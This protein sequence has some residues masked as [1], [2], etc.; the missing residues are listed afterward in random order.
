[1]LFLYLLYSVNPGQTQLVANN[2]S[3]DQ[4]DAVNYIKDNLRVHKLQVQEPVLNMTH[5][6]S[7]SDRYDIAVPSPSLI[8]TE[9][10]VSFFKTAAGETVFSQLALIPEPG[11]VPN[12]VSITAAERLFKALFTY[13]D[14]I[15]ALDPSIHLENDPKYKDSWKFF[16]RLES[17]LYPWIY[18]HWDNAF[19]INNQT[20]GRG[21]V[22][23]V[24]NNQ[25][26]FAATT[27]RAIRQLFH[28]TLPIEVFFI[29]DSDL[30]EAKRQ[31]LKSEFQDLQLIKLEDYVS[32]YYT[33]FGGWAMKP[34]AILA[35]RFT[36]VVMMDADVFFF[37][38]PGMLFEDEGYK[39]TGSLF[40]YD[41]TLLPNSTRG[42]DW[43]R[44]FLPSMSSFVPHSRWFKQVSTHEQESGVIVMNKRKALLGLLSTCKLNSKTERD[45]LVYK[46]V[47]GDKETFWIGFEVMQTPYAFV[48]SF[49]GV[50]GDHGRGGD[51]GSPDYLCGNEIH[52]DANEKPLWLN[53][54]LY[55]NK[56]AK[57]GLEY[58]NF[59]YYAFGDEWELKSGCLKSKENMYLLDPEQKTYALASI[60]LDKK[61]IEDQRL[62]EKGEW[63]FKD[64]L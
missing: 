18:P 37:Q 56:H 5:T 3:V 52:F 34:F 62:L 29:R 54:G 12:L 13:F 36:E 42:P 9:Q 10:D 19:H 57:N 2:S 4:F 64:V 39:A 25:F 48:K 44:S 35:S 51:D 43:M 40:Y 61:T 63:K 58:L 30:Q 32:D 15:L 33:K 17:T 1:M 27:I 50:I 14:S 6:S 41:R 53:G 47:Y 24:G 23:C 8:W 55:R 21:I 11:T 60:E 59:T 20:N 26:K 31:Y 7:L 16:K 38:D 46:R 49:A 28:S 22:L 45:E